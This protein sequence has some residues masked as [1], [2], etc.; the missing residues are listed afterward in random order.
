MNKKTRWITELIFPPRCPGCDRVMSMDE[1]QHGFC[2]I[3]RP[4]I[5]Y[6]SEPICKCCGKPLE[7]ESEE[8][9]GD[10][11]T[12]RH[13]F[14]QGR[15]VYIYEGPMREAMYRF[16]YSNRRAYGRIFARDA[17]SRHGRWLAG[18]NADLIVPIPMNLKK[19]RKRGYNQAT[20]LAKCLGNELGIEVDPRAVV[21]SEDTT[22]QKELSAI[23][24]RQNLKNAFNIGKCVVKSKRILLVDDIYTTGATMD[25]VSGT[26]LASGAQAVYGIYACIGLG[27]SA[28]RAN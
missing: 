23:E 17:I 4:K 21:R 6:T 7:D 16:K 10:C 27:G 9:C 3:C 26:L 8:L 25:A 28:R 18:I 14:V 11:T 12:R 5:R 24:R 19:E 20:V 22:P 1:R 13:E 15:A 2:E